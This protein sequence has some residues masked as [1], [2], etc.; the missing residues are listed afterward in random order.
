MVSTSS[1]EA[2]GAERL[3]PRTNRQDDDVFH[4]NHLHLVVFNIY[5]RLLELLRFTTI[6]KA[7]SHQHQRLLSTSVHPSL[8][9]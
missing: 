8:H 4:S 1:M 7:R 6:I 2:R 9:V 3:F 5:I